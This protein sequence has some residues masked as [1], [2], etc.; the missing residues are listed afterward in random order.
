M[1]QVLSFLF[2]L[3]LTSC[4]NPKR[5][6][7]GKAQENLVKGNSRIA[8]AMFEQIIQREGISDLAVKSA[9]ELTKIYLYEFKDYEKTIQ[10]LRFLILYS[11]DSEE[12]IKSQ[13]Q[14]AQIYFDNKAQYSDAV[15][16]FSRL[17]SMPL[18]KEE[19]SQ[20]RLSIARSYYHLGNFQQSW[21]EADSLSTTEDVSKEFDYDMRLLK[22]N[23]KMALK[24]QVNAAKM[25]E[26]ILGLYPVRAQKENIA[27]NLSLCY[28]VEDDFE[29]AIEVLKPMVEFYK[30]AE[31]INLK[32]KKLL[33][34]QLNK[35]KKRVKK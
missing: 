18:S 34:R 17:L 32:I 15:A 20:I 13:K 6:E 19:N 26:N 3:I 9:R 7:F 16:E 10:N 24:E 23:I 31:F 27:L 8:S 25:Y 12:R 22:A 35:P 14:I 30:P 29:K 33:E 21:Q 28:E 4:E 11:K 2:F 1:K 5:I